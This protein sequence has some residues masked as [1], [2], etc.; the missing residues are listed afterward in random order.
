MGIL[1][2]SAAELWE[3]ADPQSEVSKRLEA[4]MKAI[5]SY[6]AR[7]TYIGSI[8]DQLVPVEVCWPLPKLSRVSSLTINPVCHLRASPPSLHLSC[9]LHRRPDPRPRFVSLPPHPLHDHSN[10][11]PASP[12]SSVLLSSSATSAFPTTAS[13]ASSPPRWQAACTRARAIRGSTTTSRC[14]TWP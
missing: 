9:R 3:F 11:L 4:S 10:P 7:L 8:D 12:T 2:G 13:S 14:T 5:L 1:M 6:G